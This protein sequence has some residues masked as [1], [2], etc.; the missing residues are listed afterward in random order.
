[1]A[2]RLIGLDIGTNAVTAAEVAPGDP[3]ELRAFGQVGLPP[4][5]MA[6]GEVVD[7]AQVTAAIRRLWGE[8]G[9][10]RRA[11]VRVGIASPRVIVRQVE[12]PQ[13]SD[14]EVDGALR[15]QAG[16]LI[17]IP[18]EDAAFDHLVLERVV[19]AEPET[20]EEGAAG[21]A[22]EGRVRVLLAAAQRSIVDR[23]ASA[24]RDAGLKVASVDLVPLALI[25]SLGQRVAVNGEGAEALVSLGAGVSVVV[26]HTAGVP[27]FVRIVGV[28]GRDLTDAL[29]RALDVPFATAEA[30][31]RGGPDIPDDVRVEAAA[32]IQRPRAELL[33]DVRSSIDYYRTQP[34]AEDVLRTVVTGGSS[35]LPGVDEQLQ[36]LVDLPVELA[37]PR[38]GLT[39]GDI[40]F[41]EDR[42]AQVDPYLP[43]ATGLALGG[44][45]GAPRSI[46][47]LRGEPRRVGGRRAALVAGAGAAAVVALLA[48]LTLAR[49]GA[50]DSK[51][52]DLD[53]QQSRNAE[54]E[55]RI[56]ELDDAAQR[57][58][59]LEALRVQIAGLVETDVSWASLLQEIARTIP[60]DVWLTDFTGQATPPAAA[61]L[62]E[63]GRDASEPD[64]DTAPTTTA[65]TTT[66]PT[67]G[68]DVG[69]AAPEAAG[70]TVGTVNFSA[71]GLDFPSVAAWIERVAEIPAFS[72][73]WVP[74]AS[75]SSGEGTTRTLVSFESD[76]LLTE[77]AN[78]TRAETFLE[79]GREVGAEPEVGP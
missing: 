39:V 18:L 59:E 38:L 3:P 67:D 11:E 37:Q 33:E 21:P 20:A 9:L 32:A 69:T 76:A 77:S 36:N 62:P 12:L 49:Q 26:V 65:P 30:I 13:M 14:D 41:P 66:A 16:E 15:Y 70:T 79:I 56:A 64:D 10:P 5:A 75:A 55:E 2:R 22:T 48:A 54:L 24:V 52:D 29:A 51:Q 47:L 45:P 7:G 31:K 17:P 35:L 4:E 57:Q 8:V 60:N 68:A 23:L 42:L 72:G 43:V 1:M 44:L 58:L 6:E 50:V 53:A 27:R 19:P 25:R 28:G 74:N 61:E 73:L 63:G 40:G 78:S 34:D 46:D 71:M